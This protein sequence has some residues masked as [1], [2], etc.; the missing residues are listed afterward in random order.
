MLLSFSGVSAEE[1][2]Y[3]ISYEM[4]TPVRRFSLISL[5]IFPLTLPPALH[6]KLTLDIVATLH[7]DFSRA[8]MN[9]SETLSFMLIKVLDFHMQIGQT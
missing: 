9:V 6:C 4:R 5:L 1:T 8:E 2:G 3:T 7:I